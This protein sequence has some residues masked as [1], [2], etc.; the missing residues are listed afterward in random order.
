MNKLIALLHLEQVYIV[1]L[2]R[3]FYIFEVIAQLQIG[4]TYRS[5]SRFG[6]IVLLLY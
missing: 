5:F 2:L 4:I 6:S 3:N 1:K